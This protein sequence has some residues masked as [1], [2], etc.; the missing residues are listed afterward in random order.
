MFHHRFSP[1]ALALG[2][3]ILGGQAYA[4]GSKC[5]TF[6]RRP[7]VG[8]ADAYIAG[9]QPAANH[10]DSTYMVVGGE[11]PRQSVSLIYFDLEGIP[12]TAEVVSATV[13]L[14]E[15]ASNAQS[16][17][18][19]HRVTEP[20]AEDQAT[21]T[22]LA[23]AFDPFVEAT[24]DTVGPGGSGLVSFELT[25]LVQLWIHGVLENHGV[26][27]APST[28]TRAMLS[29]SEDKE[30]ARRPRL[31]VC[32]RVDPELDPWNEGVSAEAM[33]IEDLFLNRLDG[34]EWVDGRGL[35]RLLAGE[36]EPRN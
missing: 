16:T 29:S 23:A 25:G 32:F 35:S 10:G 3:L 28:G 22:D 2:T 12:E 26:W 34:D 6:Q 24:L 33:E 18:S 4:A 1:I 36:L 7:A 31:D 21:W 9:Q 27:I 20:W 17:L 11:V 14:Y 8:V 15:Q 19:I 13:T 5:Y 30:V